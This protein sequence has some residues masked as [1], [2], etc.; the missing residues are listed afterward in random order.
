MRLDAVD[1]VSK[2]SHTQF[3]EHSSFRIGFGPVGDTL[4]KNQLLD[5]MFMVLLDVTDSWSQVSSRLVAF[6]ISPQKGWKA[7]FLQRL[8]LYRCSISGLGWTFTTVIDSPNMT[9]DVDVNPI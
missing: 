7:F 8:K 5:R 4:K 1:G 6:V 3:Y 2:S 9:L